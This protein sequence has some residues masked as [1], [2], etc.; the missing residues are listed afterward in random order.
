MKKLLLLLFSILISFNSFGEIVLYCQDEL[1]TGFSKSESSSKWHVTEFKLYRSTVKFN[2]DYS[3]VTI[4]TEGDRI[5]FAC[6]QFLMDDKVICNNDVGF[7]YR[8][9]KLNKR[10]T[11][12]KAHLMG[13]I[14][15]PL[16]SS[17]HWFDSMFAG[18]CE[19]F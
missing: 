2:D 8:Y 7:S 5:Q 1:G 10:F 13:Y 15:D 12:I 11:F 16:L 9:D 17:V 18:T 19:T 4:L 3:L 6:N 14:D